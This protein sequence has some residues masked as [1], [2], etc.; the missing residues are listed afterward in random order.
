[1]TNDITNHA[2]FDLEHTTAGGIKPQPFGKYGV[3]F[4]IGGV[5]LG[6]DPQNMKQVDIRHGTPVSH[7]ISTD[8][9]SVFN[10]GSADQGGPAYPI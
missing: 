3:V 5:N 2:P 9:P 6:G 10:T 1:M 7:R 8:H 4:R